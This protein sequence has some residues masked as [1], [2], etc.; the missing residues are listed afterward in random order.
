MLAGTCCEP[1]Q[2]QKQQQQ[3]YKFQIFFPVSFFYLS[4]V[5]SVIDSKI[6]HGPKDGHQ[7]LDGVAVDDRS[8]LLEI[9]T[10][11]TTLVN[12]SWKGKS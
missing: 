9:F 10:R 6:G 11:K 1:E 3:V 2:Q 4:L 8:V 12:D 7:G 5:V